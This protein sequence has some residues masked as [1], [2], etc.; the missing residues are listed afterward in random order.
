MS[1]SYPLK[2]ISIKIVLFHD[3][4]RHLKSMLL[5]MGTGVTQRVL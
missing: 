2:Y 5:D 4:M 1:V 3:A